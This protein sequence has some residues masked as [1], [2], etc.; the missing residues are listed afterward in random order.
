MLEVNDPVARGIRIGYHD[1]NTKKSTQYTISPKQLI[2]DGKYH[3][4]S[5]GKVKISN[6]GYAH[7]HVSCEIQR[8][9]DR[10]A[11]LTTDGTVELIF[12]IKAETDE[13]KKAIKKVYLDAIEMLQP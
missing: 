12:R 2:L 10:F 3:R 6:N 13:T 8:R 5:L 4:Y 9:L 1:I 11:N 7:A